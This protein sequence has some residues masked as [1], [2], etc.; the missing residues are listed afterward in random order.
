MRTHREASRAWG[1]TEEERKRSRMGR[2]MPLPP[3]QSLAYPF[4][5]RLKFKWRGT[6]KRW[7]PRKPREKNAEVC[8]YIVPF[9]TWRCVIAPHGRWVGPIE[10]FTLIRNVNR[11]RG[12]KPLLIVMDPDFSWI[13]LVGSLSIFDPLRV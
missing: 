10:V 12:T 3:L 1:T 13:L 5:L 6:P 9:L 11:R 2:L 7:R 4:F 8:V